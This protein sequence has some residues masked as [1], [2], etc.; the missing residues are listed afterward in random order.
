MNSRP[1]STMNNIVH[2]SFV[3]ESGFN[4]SMVNLDE[5]LKKEIFKNLP[6]IERINENSDDFKLLSLS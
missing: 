3:T 2:G 1:F 5:E 6:F 4:N